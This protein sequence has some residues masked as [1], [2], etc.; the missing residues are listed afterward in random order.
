MKKIKFGLIGCGRIAQRHAEHIKTYG[1][2]VAVCDIEFKK[3]EQLAEEYDAIAYPS[4]EELLEKEKEID[5]ITICSPNGL[6]AEHTIKALNSENHVLCEKPMAINSYD[7]GEMIKTAEQN[8]KRLFVIK[9]NRFNPP[10]AAVKKIIDQGVMGKILSVQLTCFWNRNEDY[11]KNFSQ[12]PDAITILSYDALG[13]VYYVWKKN[14]GINAISDFLIKEKIK[15]KIG[16]FEFK[17]NKVLQQL[18]IYKTEN[19]RFKEY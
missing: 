11:Y 18:K 17:D 15:G 3:A 12:K 2:L 16:T 5:V 8:N 6:H 1:E 7:C 4:I 9:Q 10:I 14:N 19:N 13:L